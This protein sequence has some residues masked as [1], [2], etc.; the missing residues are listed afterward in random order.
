[1]A[2]Q[3]RILF[4]DGDFVT[5][6]VV[7]GDSVRMHDRAG[8][9]ES[10]SRL[11]PWTSTKLLEIFSAA[12]SSD[13]LARMVRDFTSNAVHGLVTGRISLK[14]RTKTGNHF[15]VHLDPDGSVSM[16]GADLEPIEVSVIFK[17]G[18]AAEIKKM[19]SAAKSASHMVNIIL[20]YL[21]SSIAGIERFEPFP[22]K[23]GG[24]VTALD[25]ALDLIESMLDP[26]FDPEA[27][28]AF[29]LEKGRAMNVSAAPTRSGF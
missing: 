25:E 17:T 3:V 8:D 11:F 26:N 14:L 4:H 1:M 9:P 5:L 22:E 20:P 15:L 18:I 21:N 10:L 27:A 13:E 16:H 7:P 23:K 28:K 2:T 12:S 29:L 19:I 6:S 24:A